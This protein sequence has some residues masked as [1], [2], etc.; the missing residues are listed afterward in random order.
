MS[1]KTPL[2]LLATQDPVMADLIVEYGSCPLLRGKG[3]PIDSLFGAIMGQQISANVARTLRSRFYE[4]YGRKSSKW[5]EKLCRAQ[6]AQ[7]RKLG[8]SEN[9]SRTI[10]ALG[11]A[12]ANNELSAAKLRR[13]SDEEVFATLTAFRGVGPWTAEIVLLSGLRRLDT[14]TYGDL[15]LKRGMQLAYGLRKLPSE[16]R[17]RE[18]SKAWHPYRAVASWYL[19]QVAG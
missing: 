4:R 17:M 2:E 11:T 10:K 14:F 7:L 6:I 8:L 3:D 5:G 15:G 1:E 13:A 16:R 9:K 19:W 18:I 12:L